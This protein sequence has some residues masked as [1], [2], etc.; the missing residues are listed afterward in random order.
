MGMFLQKP[1]PKLNMEVLKERRLSPRVPAILPVNVSK[2]NLGETVNISE[3]GICLAVSNPLASSMI[4]SILIDPAFTNPLELQGEVIW[5]KPHAEENRFRCGV[6]FLKIQDRQSSILKT[7]IE[8][9]GILNKEF[10]DETKHMR[11][12]I[13]HIKNFFDEFDSRNHDEQKGIEFIEVNK[14]SILNKLTIHFN[15]IWDIVKDF[16]KEEFNLHQKYYQKMLGPYLL[17]PIETNRYILQKPLGYAGDYITMIY[18]Y[19]YHKGRYLGNSSYEK[20]INHYTC[21]IPISCSNIK[22]KEFFKQKIIETISLKDT[23]KIL[24]VG[25]GPARELLELL[26]LGAINKILIYDCLDF[27]KRALEYVCK[28]LS[29]IENRNREPLHIRFINKN[30]LDLVKNK[31]LEEI[32][33]WKYDLVYCAG[34]FDYLSNRISTKLIETLYSLLKS[35]GTLIICNADKETQ[36]HRAYYEMLGDWRFEHRTKLE[37]LEWTKHISDAKEI[38]FEDV[39]KNNN[40]LYLSIRKR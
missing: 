25:C 4:I 12:T 9:Y 21:N 1:F 3:T 34:V 10:I 31:N 23:P 11:Y 18:I 7:A 20:L 16:T 30:I 19:A 13:Q 38:K 15:K 26:E 32:Y 35:E 37:M 6:Q 22:R 14:P 8:Q 33:K 24:N 17:D 36:N 40:Y 28:N 2:D 27:E 5:T 29:R 39:G